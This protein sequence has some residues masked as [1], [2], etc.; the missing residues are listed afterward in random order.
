MKVLGIDY[1]N[2]GAFYGKHSFRLAD[3][4]LTLVLGDN[5]DE[6]RM[7]SNGSAKSTMFEALDWCWYGKVPKDDH[8]DSLINEEA[9]TCSVSVSLEDDD[10]TQAVI[11][12]SRPSSLQFWVGGAEKTALDTDKTQEEITKF[13]G[14]DR[15][16]FHASVLFAQTDLLHFA[17]VGD[18]ARIKTLSKIIPELSQVDVLLEKAKLEGAIAQ[19]EVDTSLGKLENFRGQLLGLEA[20]DYTDSK[21]KWEEKR[22]L[23]LN[24]AANRLAELSAYVQSN[25]PALGQLAFLRESQNKALP[26]PGS[27]RPS[28][29]PSLDLANKELLRCQ[30]DLS[31]ARSNFSRIQGEINNV[32]SVGVG[33]C[34]RCGQLVSEDHLEMEVAKL[35]AELS[36][37]AVDMDSKSARAYK[38]S[39]DV[40]AAHDRAREIQVQWDKAEQDRT[41]VWSQLNDQIAALTKLESYIQSARA[42]MGGLQRSIDG[43]K[44]AINPFEEEERLM[45]ERKESLRWSIAGAEDEL[46]K[47]EENLEYI[48][49]WVKAF[50][51]KGLKNYILDSKLQEMTDAANHWVKL[52]TGGT[53]WMRFETQKVGRSSKKLSNELNIRVF[54]YNPDGRISDRNYKSWSGGEKKRVSLAIDFGLSRLV[55]KRAKKRYD[56]LI[57]DELFKHVDKLGGEAL[58]E[59]LAEL[60]NEKSS[61]FVIEHDENFQSRFDNRIVVQRRNGRSRILENEDAQEK[62]AIPSNGQAAPRTK[63]GGKKKPKR[64]PVRQR[65]QG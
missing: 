35:T 5:L 27:S 59:M 21:R 53:F 19:K 17:D 54:R 32:R 42:E 26:Q 60:G 63:V 13:L 15:D 51:P 20:V 41:K 16:V 3:R 56:L 64:T 44:A 4:G 40:A 31:V 58:A 23:D 43:F 52:L 1:E 8:A 45:L 18:A 61:L 10:G 47:L 39:S 29:D 36:V 50:G 24:G 25:E 7:N 62:S 6:P 34:S 12:R 28:A 48:D 37:V 49:Y 55:A 11:K 9:K 2:Y 57:L 33:A 14:M 38:A 65:V 22:N 46:G 30:S